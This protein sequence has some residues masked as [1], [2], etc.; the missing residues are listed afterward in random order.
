MFST[1]DPRRL[2]A[3]GGAASCAAAL[4]KSACAAGQI[5][6]APAKQRPGQLRA[7]RTLLCAHQHDRKPRE[8]HRGSALVASALRR[9]NHSAALLL[10]L[11]A[12]I[13]GRWGTLLR[14]WR[15]HAPRR[16][17]FPPPSA[18]ARSHTTP[19][20]RRASPGP[21]STPAGPLGALGLPAACTVPHN[22]PPTRSLQ[23]ASAHPAHPCVQPRRSRPSAR[24]RTHPA[25]QSR[26]HAGTR[27]PT[28]RVPINP[29]RLC[30]H[31]PA[32]LGRRRHER[33]CGGD[34]AV[35]MARSGHLRELGRDGRAR[36][37]G[38]GRGE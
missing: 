12:H 15:A 7:C 17:G 35:R 1:N 9:R 23:H 19:A 11:P 10:R 25:P 27:L 14:V 24:F 29:R 6:S 38:A 4:H 13:G 21:R 33:A 8:R 26:Q 30:A 22:A 5:R 16:F 20:A 31:R 2:P 32:R 28:P 3:R 18:R 34:G 37:E 36:L